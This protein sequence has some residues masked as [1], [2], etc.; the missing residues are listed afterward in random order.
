MTMMPKIAGA[1][2]GFRTHATEMAQVVVSRRSVSARL[3]DR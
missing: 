2:A 1:A 3:W